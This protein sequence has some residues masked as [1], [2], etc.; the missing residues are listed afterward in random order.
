MG[1]VA[2]RA[3]RDGRRGQAWLKRQETQLRWSQSGFQ[4]SQGP[5]R[6]HMVIARGY[7][8][9]RAGFTHSMKNNCRSKLRD[10]TPGFLSSKK[11]ATSFLTN[12]QT[13]TPVNANPCKCQP[14]PSPPAQHTHVRSKSTPQPS[15]PTPES[16]LSTL[17]GLWRTHTKG[18]HDS[19]NIFISSKLVLN[20]THQLHFIT[21]EKIYILMKL[22]WRDGLLLKRHLPQNPKDPTSIPG[23]HK[24]RGKETRFLKVIL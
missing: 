14:N 5:P 1:R 10:S 21:Q 22:G 8:P 16:P 2:P 6:G 24:I 20:W 3:P 9:T 12:N 18:I 17:G 13:D 11:K 19:T 4:L 15:L 7:S 23:S